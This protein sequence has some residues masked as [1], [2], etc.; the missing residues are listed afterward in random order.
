[1]S[2]QNNQ[3]NNGGGNFPREEADQLLQHSTWNGRE[4]AN[5]KLGHVVFANNRSPKRDG[6]KYKQ[7][8]LV[9]NYGALLAA[10]NS[11]AIKV[12]AGGFLSLDLSQPFTPEQKAKGRE[13]VRNLPQNQGAPQGQPQ[14]NWQNPQQ[15]MHQGLPQGQVAPQGQ[16]FPNAGQPQWNPQN[17]GIPQQPQS[18][19]QAQ[20]WGGQP[21]APQGQQ[22]WN[23]NGTP[24]G[25]Y[26]PF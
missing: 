22:Q 7:S 24:N 14:Q 20:G 2:Y 25:D 4:F 19:P 18:M 26:T 15:G 17:Q 11:G 10:V 8:K 6:S 16:Q 21:A 12:T 9:L 5:Q 1:M 3:N 13:V 23:P